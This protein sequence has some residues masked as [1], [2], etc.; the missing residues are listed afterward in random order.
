MAPATCSGTVS[1]SSSAR[2]SNSA[3]CAL[4]GERVSDEDVSRP[5]PHEGLLVE[6]LRTGRTENQH[7]GLLE[8]RDQV[9]EQVEQRLGRPVDVVDDEHEQCL[10]SQRREVP[11]PGVV[12]PPFHVSVD[13]HTRRASWERETHRPRDRLDD[14]LDLIRG[15]R[16]LDRPSQLREGD[17]GSV[18]V[19]DSR[20]RARDLDQGQIGDP[21]AVRD[22]TADDDA[23]VVQPIREL[24]EKP[25][26]A[27]ARLTEDRDQLR[28]L[29]ALDPRGRETEHRDLVVAADQRRLLPCSASLVHRHGAAKSFP[30]SNPF[31]LALR[32]EVAALRVGDHAM[33]RSPG[34]LADQDGSGLGELLQAGGDVDGVAAHDQLATGGCL[35]TRDDLPGVD[36]DPQADLSPVPLCDASRERGE[37][38]PNRE[39]GPH[40]ALRV[41]LVRLRDAEHGEDR[42]ARRTSR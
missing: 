16:V 19:Q 29:L 39:R 5:V 28:R 34:S 42:V 33:R 13:R 26:L 11:R 41:V 25:R 17:V 14:A 32:V 24:G 8:P 27:H 18:V 38:I 4:K 40:C 6:Q 30:A 37:R 36:P 1:V 21:V 15:Q 2:R 22:A 23:G 9:V 31:A 10:S 3:D 35:A 20:K 12:Q 7:R